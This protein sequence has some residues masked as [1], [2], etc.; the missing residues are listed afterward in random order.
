MAYNRLVQ[1]C[2]L[3]VGVGMACAATA[4][5]LTQRDSLALSTT[6]PFDT[7]LWVFG[8]D[9]QTRQHLIARYGD[10][11]F[12]HNAAQPTLCPSSSAS[13]F[14]HVRLPLTLE[15]NPS[16]DTKSQRCVPP[17]ATYG[18]WAISN[19]LFK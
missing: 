9:G 6:F 2:A 8:A 1:T 15:T 18:T 11:V 7:T 13:D 14:A 16:C 12:F 3:A 5:T 4:G 10:T 19:T 17:R